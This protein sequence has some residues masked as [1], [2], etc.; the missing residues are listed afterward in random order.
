MG[1]CRCTCHTGPYAPCSVP[2]GCGHLH[3]DTASDSASRPAGACLTHRPPGEGRPWQRADAGYV[4]CKDC[5]DRLHRWLSCTAVD[6]DG[7]PDSIPVLYALLNPRPGSNGDTSGVRPP[8]FAS[9]SPANDHIVAMRDARTAMAVRPGD[10]RSAPAILRA[11]VLA[12][13]DER[14]DDDA[15]DQP[16]Y[17]SRRAALPIAVPDAARWLDS[18]IDWL[19][20]QEMVGE[21]HAE[22]AALRSQLR[23]IG[24]R[25]YKIGDCPNT[26]DEGDRTRECGAPLFAPLHSDE[27]RCFACGRLWARPDWEELGKLL[28]TKGARRS[29]V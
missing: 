26:I 27:I 23:S 22:L 6:G 9:R 21:F 7:R 12:V 3:R 17:R 2:G 10:P 28:P 15:L 29:V 11:W 19:T 16:D 5:A 25:R 14:Y 24:S 18:Q 4:T 20:R 8:G 1:D 13:W